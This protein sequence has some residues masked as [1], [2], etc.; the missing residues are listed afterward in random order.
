M[1]EI[2]KDFYSNLYSTKQSDRMSRRALLSNM[3]TKINKNTARCLKHLINDESVVRAALKRKL[4][5]S[6]GEDD[7]PHD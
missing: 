2:V 5:R 3:T 4:D 6:L 7:I 1:L